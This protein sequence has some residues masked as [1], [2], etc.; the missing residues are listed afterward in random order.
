MDHI[1]DHQISLFLPN[2]VLLKKRLLDDLWFNQLNENFGVFDNACL[3]KSQALWHD[4]V[5]EKN[6]EVFV[7]DLDVIVE[8]LGHNEGDVTHVTL[9]MQLKSQINLLAWDSMMFED[10]S[11]NNDVWIEPSLGK[12]AHLLFSH[13]HLWVIMVKGVGRQTHIEVVLSLVQT[14]LVR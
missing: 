14:S 5:S 12:L 8:P 2:K 10:H 4:L 13:L 11:D 7:R 3:F 9:S 6:P 1:F